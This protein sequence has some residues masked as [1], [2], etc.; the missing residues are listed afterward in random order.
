[1]YTNKKICIYLSGLL[2]LAQSCTIEKRNYLSGY[3][4]DWKHKNGKVES[5]AAG[6]YTDTPE[7]VNK[8][9]YREVKQVETTVSEP[10][11][12]S[13]ETQY[14]DRPTRNDYAVSASTDNFIGSAISSTTTIDR[15]EEASQLHSVTKSESNGK[16]KHTVVKKKRSIIQFIKNLANPSSGSKSQLVAA[17]LCFFLG[18][19]G[20]HRF[21]LGYTTIGVIQLLTLGGCGIW[22]LI[23]LIRILLGDLGPKNGDYDETI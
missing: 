11:P 13:T 2:L 20:I 1:M 15:K 10:S 17:L 14:T 7:S 3:H 23:D 16:D 9:Q 22:A 21:Y 18:G 4:I 12:V 8:L 6:R 19:L 5:M